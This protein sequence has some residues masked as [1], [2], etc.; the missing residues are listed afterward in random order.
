MDSYGYDLDSTKMYT[1]YEEL[2]SDA[3]Q[4]ETLD[5]IYNIINSLITMNISYKIN[6]NKN[7]DVCFT[8][9]FTL[10]SFSKWEEKAKLFNRWIEEANL[11]NANTDNNYKILLDEQFI[12]CV[13]IND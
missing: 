3:N 11:I 4:E 5:K 13:G 2:I 8:Y 1:D 12:V 7:M 9:D 10:G 6:S